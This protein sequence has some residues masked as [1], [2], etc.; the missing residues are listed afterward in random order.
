MKLALI[1]HGVG[2]LRSVEKALAAAGGQVTLTADPDTILAAE[3]VVLPGVGAFAD[4]MRG[5]QSRGLVETVMSIARRGT[6]LLGICVGMQMLLDYSV[7]HGRHPGLSLLPGKV[8]RFAEQQTVSQGLKVPQT[9]WNQVE[10]AQ[11]T[12]LLRDLPGGSYAYFNHR[13]FRV[14]NTIP[15]ILFLET[16][17]AACFM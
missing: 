7:E 10:P 6:P 9:G 4:A 17:L 3:K 12:P 13:A 16:P 5:L 1:D 11:E 2:N 14:L 8:V 15:P